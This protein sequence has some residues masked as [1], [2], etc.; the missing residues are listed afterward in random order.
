MERKDSEFQHKPL[1]NFWGISLLLLLILV[2]QIVGNS[3][4]NYLLSFFYKLPV[5][6]IKALL[7]QPDF[8]ALSINLGRW[9]N[10]IQFLFYMGLPALIF[11][12]AN[13]TQPKDYWGTTKNLTLKTTLFSVVLGMSA[14]PVV[15]VLTQITKQIPMN[16]VFAETAHKLATIRETLFENMLDMQHLG[17]LLVCIFILAFLPAILEEYLFRGLILKIALSQYKKPFFALIFQALVFAILHLSL[18]ELPGILLMGFLFGFIAY[19]QQN[20]W[21]N[22]LTHFTFNGTTIILHYYLT[23]AQHSFAT[24]SSDDVLANAMIAI[25]ASLAMGLSL[26]ALT[27]KSGS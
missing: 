21:Y 4:S 20:L 14:L 26:F 2:F 5:T 11:T 19:R 10:L 7:I 3:V 17:E 1:S 15:S 13:L 23:H 16:G 18:F 24:F 9:S 25:P 6:D 22:A 8:S 27:R 12:F